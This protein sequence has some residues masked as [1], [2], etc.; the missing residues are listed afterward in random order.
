MVVGIVTTPISLKTYPPDQKRASWRE[1]GQAGQVKSLTTAGNKTFQHIMTRLL[2]QKSNMNGPWNL[3]LKPHEQ[4][5]SPKISNCCVTIIRI[6]ETSE[7]AQFWKELAPGRP[8]F[9][10]LG[11][12]TKL[13]R[14]NNRTTEG[15]NQDLFFKNAVTRAQLGPLLT[16]TSTKGGQTGWQSEPSR[17]TQAQ[18]FQNQ[19]TSWRNHHLTPG[20]RTLSHEDQNHRCQQLIKPGHNN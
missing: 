18:I 5:E 20:R 4:N 16:K 1:K 8:K 3:R 6:I 17:H 2:G 13:I 7:Q 11:T 9:A 10:S 14:H 12:K 19:T 15:Q